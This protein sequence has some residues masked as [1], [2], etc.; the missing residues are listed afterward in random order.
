MRRG[1]PTSTGRIVQGPGQGRVE[2]LVDQGG[3]AGTGHPGHGHQQSQ[4]GC[5]TVDAGQV[6]F[7]GSFGS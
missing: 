4:R 7:R 2:D 5:L 1:R 6:V 3:F